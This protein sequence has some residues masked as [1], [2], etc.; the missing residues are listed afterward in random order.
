MNDHQLKLLLDFHREAKLLPLLKHWK[1]SEEVGA[2]YLIAGP[3]GVGSD[4]VARMLA[5]FLSCTENGLSKEAQQVSLFGEIQDTP[6]S[7]SPS[8]EPC[9][10]C[11]SCLHP[12]FVEIF[13]EASSSGREGKIKVD[14]LDVIHSKLGYAADEGQFRIF[15]LHHADHMTPQAANSLLKVLEEPQPGWVFL[16]TASDK[17]L[18]LPTLLSRSQVISLTPLPESLLKDAL[19]PNEAPVLARMSHGSLTR[20]EEWKDPSAWEFRTLFF[21]FLKNPARNLNPLL[22]RA[23]KDDRH[24]G[25]LLDLLESSTHDLLL[26]SSSSTESNR[27]VHYDELKS[28]EQISQRYRNEFTFLL[29]RQEEISQARTYRSVP[30]NRKLAVQSLLLPWM[31]E[32]SA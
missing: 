14:Q 25:L 6:S 19:S 30:L 24:Y 23:S 16:L 8:L 12:S 32:A 3:E 15:I 13:P 4:E 28:L 21:D 10:A 2:S 7:S 5:Q 29:D 18:L 26:L 11:A 27:S 31:S 17:T 9:G 1:E 20:L 22:D